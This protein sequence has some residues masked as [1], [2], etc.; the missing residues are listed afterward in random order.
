MQNLF[1]LRCDLGDKAQRF[2][3]A[4][5]KL[6]CFCMTACKYMSQF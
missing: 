3:S 4:N 5:V 6:H 1:K 2:Q